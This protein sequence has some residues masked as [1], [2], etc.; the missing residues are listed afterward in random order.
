MKRKRSILPLLHWGRGI[1]IY[2]ISWEIWGLSLLWC[3]A[4][5]WLSSISYDKNDDGQSDHK[6]R[7]LVF[8]G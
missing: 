4:N 5:H 2:D 8:M 1:S 7:C 6:Y 3:E